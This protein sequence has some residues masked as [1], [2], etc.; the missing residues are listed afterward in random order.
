M[1]Q[2]AG[3]VY[4]KGVHAVLPDDSTNPQ[5]SATVGVSTTTTVV[6]L[7]KEGVAAAKEKNATRARTLFRQVTRLQPNNEYA[8]HWLSLL[9]ECPEDAQIYL[10]KVLQVNAQNRGAQVGLRWIDYKIQRRNPADFCPLCC[11]GRETTGASDCKNC[12]AHLSLS[13]VIDVLQKSSASVEKMEAA[14][15]RWESLMLA[16]ADPTV[17]HVNLALCYV[18]LGQGA[19]ALEQLRMAEVAGSDL[20]DLPAAI[21]AL[22]EAPQ[23]DKPRGKVEAPV[24]T[25]PQPVVTAASPVRS[26]P[27]AQPIKAPPPAAKVQVK[28]EP[29]KVEPVVVA[30][31]AAPA[32][33]VE[34]AVAA[35]PKVEEASESE[36][37]RKTVLLVD[38]SPTVRMLVTIT[39]KKEGYEVDTA[40]HGLE[41]LGKIHDYVPDLIL[42]DITMPNDDGFKL[43]E[44]IKGQDSTR[45]VP[46]IFLSGRKNHSDKIR[47]RIVG[48][49]GYITKPF[50]PEQLVRMVNKYCPRSPSAN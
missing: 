5:R 29:P 4:A 7:L 45:D 15:E 21:D 26:A 37:T 30:E 36:A 43:C 34:P 24:T 2:G 33:P 8:W 40:A 48:S 16:G 25:L 6:S 27:V 13:R 9:A 49:S 31:V 47:G 20:D 42:L 11:G 23:A 17:G 32:T 39:L 38:D 12:G 44:F 14:L 41:A 28:V 22:T 3:I 10:Q 19:L 35:P 50:E 46:I 1:R 18:N